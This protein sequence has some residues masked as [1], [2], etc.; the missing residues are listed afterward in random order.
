MNIGFG[1]F[2][3]FLLVLLVLFGNIPK[4][5]KNKIKSLNFLFNNRPN[6]VDTIIKF[7]NSKGAVIT[8]KVLVKYLNSVIMILCANNR[9]SYYYGLKIFLI[10]HD[11]LIYK[12]SKF[13][14]FYKLR[15]LLY[16]YLCFQNTV[17]FYNYSIKYYFYKLE[18]QYKF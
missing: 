12:T 15:F 7:S 8:E 6:L 14:F 10:I 17:I 18:Y 4:I 16:L 11:C 3:I 9:I 2:L 1:Q 13:C 5:F